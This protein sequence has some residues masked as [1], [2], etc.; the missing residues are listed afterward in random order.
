MASMTTIFIGH[1][2]LCTCIIPAAQVAGLEESPPMFAITPV[3]SQGRDMDEVHS[4][5]TEFLAGEFSR[6]E[7]EELHLDGQMVVRIFLHEGGDRPY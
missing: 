6:E 1:L 4:T 5:F 2:E 7:F 3:R